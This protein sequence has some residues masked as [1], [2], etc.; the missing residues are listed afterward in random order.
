M[1]P[2]LAPLVLTPDLERLARRCVWFLEPALALSRP[3]HFIAHVL[4]Y[5]TH[6]DVRT[7]RRYVSDEALRLALAEAPPGV[8]DARSWAYWQLKLNAHRQAPPLPERRL[9]S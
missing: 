1:T 9:P 5:G 2:L 7:L 4:T 8:F 6:D 3:A